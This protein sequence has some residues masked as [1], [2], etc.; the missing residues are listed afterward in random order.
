MHRRGHFG[1]ITIRGNIPAHAKLACGSALS[2]HLGL[3]HGVRLCYR[4]ENSTSRGVA[5]GTGAEAV[6]VNPSALIPVE[7]HLSSSTPSRC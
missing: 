4:H 3:D 6:D 5:Q 1:W 7:S 2:L